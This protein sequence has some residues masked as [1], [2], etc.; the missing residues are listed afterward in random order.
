M[1]TLDA[2]DPLTCLQNFYQCL[3][4]QIT[5]VNNSANKLQNMACHSSG[6]MCFLWFPMHDLQNP[7][8]FLLH[9]DESPL[10]FWSPFHSEK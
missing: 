2:I 6:Q 7:L 4:T 9:L 8:A 3:E 5:S 1:D 10:L